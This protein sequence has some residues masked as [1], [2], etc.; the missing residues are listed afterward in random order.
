MKQI[1]V[2]DNARK[3][4]HDMGML[5]LGFVL[6]GACFGVFHILPTSLGIVWIAS[7]VCFYGTDYGNPERFEALESW[8]AHDDAID[9]QEAMQAMCRAL[10][11]IFGVALF[12][13]LFWDMYFHGFFMRLLGR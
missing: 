4:E 13:S 6:G 11:I 9:K 1:F 3:I 12:L 2:W 5:I 10:I 7:I 8:D